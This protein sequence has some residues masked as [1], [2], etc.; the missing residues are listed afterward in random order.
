MQCAGPSASR[1]VSDNHVVRAAADDGSAVV[2]QTVDSLVTTVKTTGEVVK[3]GVDIAGKGVEQAQQAFSAVSPYVSKGVNAVGPVV[4]DLVERAKPIASSVANEAGKFVSSAAPQTGKALT[5]IGVSP[6]VMS[7]IE[8]GAS[9]TVRA[10]KSLLEMVYQFVTT[11]QPTVLAEYAAGAVVAYLLL[12]PLAAAGFGLLRGYAGSVSPAA[13]LDS[14]AT[15]SNVVLVDIRTLR[16]KES[17]GIPDVRK[18]N[19]YIELEV[20]QI[21][22]P[23]VRRVLKNVGDLE[24][25]MTAIQIAN[26]KKIN[27]GTKIYIM[28]K[29]ESTSKSGMYGYEYMW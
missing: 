4:Q 14:M 6:Q 11:T 19:E 17:S 26:L 1:Y 9:V 7:S 12:P 5:D 13:V 8:K 28:D 16:E 20:A 21:S 24:V 27:K 22:D 10:S 15:D 25:I 18:K 23:R 2:D 3:Q 29:A